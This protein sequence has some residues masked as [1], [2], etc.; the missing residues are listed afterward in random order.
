MHRKEPNSSPPPCPPHEMPQ[1][2]P[3]PLQLLRQTHAQTASA[4]SASWRGTRAGRP[5]DPSRRSV[6]RPPGR[7]APQAL[8]AALPHAPA[9]G[10][11]CRKA[12]PP[13][14]QISSLLS[15]HSV[16]VQCTFLVFH[17]PSIYMQSSAGVLHLII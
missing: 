9:E 7:P 16:P 3:P 17:C 4:V 10:L 2:R 6:P 14:S 1:P 5:L 15:S 11:P 8:P 12:P 13:S